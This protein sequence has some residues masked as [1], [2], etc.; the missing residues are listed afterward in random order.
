MK[1][2]TSRSEVPQIQATP[3]HAYC[4]GCGMFQ[5]DWPGQGHTRDGLA[6]CCQDCAEGVQCSC[7]DDHLGAVSD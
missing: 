3:K 5:S 4:P 1:S 2:A 6:Y 7:A